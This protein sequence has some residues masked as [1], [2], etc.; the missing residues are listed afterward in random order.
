MDNR[1]DVNVKERPFMAG[2]TRMADVRYSVGE[3]V[4]AVVGRALGGSRVFLNRYSIDG[5]R[6]NPATPV[7]QGRHEIQAWAVPEGGIEWAAVG[8]FILKVAAYAAVSA[9]AGY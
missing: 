1:I 7:P 9:A 6:C 3:P 2:V 8:A 4:A 5:K